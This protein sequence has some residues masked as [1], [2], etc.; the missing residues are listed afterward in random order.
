MNEITAAQVA[1]GA[2]VHVSTARRWLASVSYV[3]ERGPRGPIRKYEVSAVLAWLKAGDSFKVEAG[4]RL[5]VHL[6]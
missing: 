1:R 5:E 3:E 4:Q 6:G 2:G